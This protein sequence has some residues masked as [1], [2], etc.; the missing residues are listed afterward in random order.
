ME[1]NTV[2][3]SPAE[4]LQAFGALGASRTGLP[5]CVEALMPN[6]SGRTVIASI[7][8]HVSFALGVRRETAADQISFRPDR[9]SEMSVIGFEGIRF[10]DV[11]WG[12][13]EL[14]EPGVHRCGPV[15]HNVVLHNG[16]CTK[17]VLA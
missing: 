8:T 16:P 10:N 2:V 17:E 11:R 1:L 13:P 14:V 12:D 5:C 15:A 3:H 7:Q 9:L 6:V 4:T